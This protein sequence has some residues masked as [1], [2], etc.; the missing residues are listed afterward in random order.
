MFKVLLRANLSDYSSRRSFNSH[1]IFKSNKSCDSN[2]KIRSEF[3]IKPEYKYAVLNHYYTKTIKEYC[4]KLKRGR[5]FLNKTLL[6]NL[7][8]HYFSYFFQFN[9]KTKEKIAIFNKE[10]NTTYK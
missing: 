2:G 4:K 5:A 6:S 8:Y 9:K 7:K 10:F 1:D 3:H